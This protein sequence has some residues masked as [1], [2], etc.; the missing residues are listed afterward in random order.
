MPQWTTISNSWGATEDNWK[1]VSN[2]WGND[3][4]DI[5]FSPTYE[6]EP[7]QVRK[8]DTGF[9]PTY[10]T[11]PEPSAISKGIDWLDSLWIN[12]PI[13]K[14]LGIDLPGMGRKVSN[15]ITDPNSDFFDPLLKYTPAGI[16]G[17]RPEVQRGFLGGSI[18]GA[19]QVAEGFTTP[20]NIATIGFGARAQG[21]LKAAKALDEAGD[22]VGALRNFNAAQKLITADKAFGVAQVPTGAAHAYK[23]Y[24]QGDPTQIGFGIAEMAGGA[25]AAGQHRPSYTPEPGLAKIAEAPSIYKDLPLTQDLEFNPHAYQQQVDQ[26][27]SPGRNMLTDTANDIETKDRI[28]QGHVASTDM[29]TF[30]VDPFAPITD[31]LQGMDI[32]TRITDAPPIPP[33]I[34][35]DINRSFDQPDL[36]MGGDTL[37]DP[38]IPSRGFG[39]EQGGD[40]ASGGDWS[41]RPPRQPLRGDEAIPE[42]AFQPDEGKA[43]NAEGMES[44]LPGEN[45]SNP[46][47]R[48]AINEETRVAPEGG[49]NAILISHPELRD[50]ALAIYHESNPEMISQNFANYVKQR[51][52]TWG[53]YFEAQ[54]NRLRHG[55][56]EPPEVVAAFKRAAA[57]SD[58]AQAKYERASSRILRGRAE[59]TG[60]PRGGLFDAPDEFH[61][62]QS[63]VDTGMG[64][65][66]LREQPTSPTFGHEQG[67]DMATGG[68][69]P[70]E[71]LRTRLRRI[72]GRDPTQEELNAA[73]GSTDESIINQI[74]DARLREQIGAGESNIPLNPTEIAINNVLHAYARNPALALTEMNKYLAHLPPAEIRK[75][76]QLII[77]ITSKLHADNKGKLRIPDP[78]ESEPHDPAWEETPAEALEED[79]PTVNIGGIIDAKKQ[80]LRDMSYDP[81]GMSGWEADMTLQRVNRAREVPPGEQM[82]LGLEDQRPAN[83]IPESDQVRQKDVL[84][85][86]TLMEG[87]LAGEAQ[88]IRAL[89]DMYGRPITPS[90]EVAALAEHYTRM[91]DTAKAAKYNELADRYSAVEQGQQDMFKPNRMEGG[92]EDPNRMSQEWIDEQNGRIPPKGPLGIRPTGGARGMVPQEP[93]NP[94]QSAAVKRQQAVD[95][96]IR[97]EN[98]AREFE[99]QAKAAMDTGN[100]EL[101]MQH[102]AASQKHRDMAATANMKFAKEMKGKMKEAERFESMARARE[103]AGDKEGASR[104]KAQ[105]ETEYLREAGQLEL[106][107]RKNL[108]AQKM[109][110]MGFEL[111][112]K[113]IHAIDDMDPAD[114]SHHLQKD[115]AELLLSSVDEGKPGLGVEDVPSGR[116]HLAET[117]I[118]IR[119]K[120]G[121]PIAHAEMQTNRLTG[122]GDLINWAV[123]QE[124]GMGQKA[125]LPLAMELE[126]RGGLVPKGPYSADTK[127]FLQRLATAVKESRLFK[128]ETGALNLGNWTGGKWWER[129]KDRAGWGQGY[130]T[131]KRQRALAKQQ[132]QWID[133]ALAMPANM[134]TTGDL[135]AP[136]RQG[137][138]LF[139][140][141]E[142]WHAAYTMFKGLSPTAFNRI[143]A[144]LKNMRIMQ[145]QGVDPKTGKPLPSMAEQWGM[146]MFAPAS[147]PGPHAKGAASNWL[148]TGRFFN[149]DIPYI[150]KGWAKSP[151]AMMIRASNRAFITFANHLNVNRLQYLA[152]RA[153]DNSLKAHQG[154]VRKQGLL[155]GF[156]P[157]EFR[158]G[159]GKL[160]PDIDIGLHDSIDFST[161]T[162]GERKA[163]ANFA[164]SLDPYNNKALGKELADAVNTMTG[165]APLKTHVLPFR[166]A[167]LNLENHARLLGRLFFAP[168]LMASRVRMMNPSTYI[169]ASPTARKQYVGGLFGAAAGYTASAL[170]LKNGAEALGYDADINMD[171]TSADFMKIRVGN[172]RM[173]PSG[174]IAPYLVLYSRLISGYYT[175][176]ATGRTSELGQGFQA[177]TAE[178]LKDRFLTNKQEPI[179][180]FVS[181]MMAASEHQPVFMKDR[182]LQMMIPMVAQDIWEVSKEDPGL[183]PLSVGTFF[184]HGGQVYQQ[185]VAGTRFTDP[186][187][188][189]V[190]AGGGLRGLIYGADFQNQKSGPG[191]R[192]MSPRKLGPRNLGPRKPTPRQ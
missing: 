71:D 150:T 3:K 132:V 102:A 53:A 33:P 175:S 99:K 149:Q 56:P 12:Q 81:S 101:A 139:H 145:S 29:P 50:E 9:H 121:K 39:M 125:I 179:A 146:K 154:S 188:E 26:F 41:Q 111:S 169:M 192:Q 55:I 79:I 147:Q 172:Y 186:K 64:G 133:E 83:V 143:D 93:A 176:S 88:K 25:G 104:L 155:G 57:L 60:R 135:S 151:M 153:Q 84:K 20:L 76:Q 157:S 82:M 178:T 148:E 52:A 127:N 49:I 130:K 89:H 73:A 164:D 91:G 95:E 165:H 189:K 46:T 163:W 108:L 115:F 105:A 21:L 120:N 32:A 131:N 103:A 183:I 51:E 184:G 123:S 36:G 1:P 18:E 69:I 43:T 44:F 86:A 72:L 19:S 30:D 117:H 128:E 80:A 45:V 181:D 54:N 144:E 15:Y 168:G 7:P 6:N 28:L 166:G 137:L 11:E 112:D 134:T 17:A 38:S 90:E 138:M 109:R 13:S 170:L 42:M 58:L 119:D 167:E 187:N 173:D 47:S 74:E 34:Y 182:M 152:D 59:T 24:E 48:A 142:F 31:R 98:Q 100:P 174:G 129:L 77:Q 160:M 141:P 113:T 158:F 96:V 68:G 70:P 191:P 22:T 110:E 4:P 63:D 106:R 27:D 180:K 124:A 114:L 10:E 14:S 23:G 94:R 16:L 159:I 118:T 5:G 171:P 190:Y 92:S 107:F 156:N 65:D 136:G 87:G 2:S 67:G 66:P 75:A 185:G 85:V 8:Y 62:T 126:K 177:T 37:R 35:G 116:P 61:P 78:L 97:L 140:T 122:E 162:K 40:M 161:A